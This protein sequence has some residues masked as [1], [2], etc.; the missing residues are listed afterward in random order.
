MITFSEWFQNLQR[1][2][3]QLE[4]KFQKRTIQKFVGGQLPT[5]E[6]AMKI[7]DLVSN[8]Q[9]IVGNLYI[10]QMEQMCREQQTPNSKME[11]HVIMFHPKAAPRPRFTRYGRPYNPKDYTDWKKDLA[12]ILAKLDPQENCILDIEFH[13]VSKK[14]VWGPHTI[15]PDGDHLLKAFQD[16]LQLAGFVSDDCRFWDVR[17][18][19]Y[20]SHSSKIICRITT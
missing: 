17:I 8:G 1:H 6:Q 5:H 10:E 4:K 20:Y 16:A 18:R 7:A 14:A 2:F 12:T 19:K 11:E 9:E 3:P 13:F 15:K